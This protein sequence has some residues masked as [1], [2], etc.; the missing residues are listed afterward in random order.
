[1]SSSSRRNPPRSSSSRPNPP[2]S[3]RPASSLSPPRSM[4][5]RSRSPSPAPSSDPGS[6]TDRQDELEAALIAARTVPKLVLDPPTSPKTGSRRPRLPTSP[7]QMLDSEVASPSRPSAKR[8]RGG[9]AAKKGKGKEKAPIKPEPAKKLYPLSHLPKPAPSFWA[10]LAASSA[11]SASAFSGSPSISSPSVSPAPALPS[12]A[13]PSIPAIPSPLLSAF[14]GPTAFAPAP[15]PSPAAPSSSAPSAA[16]SSA[17]PAA[18]SSTPTVVS[19]APPLSADQVLSILQHPLFNALLANHPAA[20]PGLD[21]LPAPSVGLKAC[22]HGLPPADP[23]MQLDPNNLIDHGLV[24]HI[25]KEG[26]QT[27]F[28][29]NSLL[30]DL[31]RAVFLL[32]G[33]I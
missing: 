7:P 27:Y 31:T 22:V 8:P 23:A 10:S 1:M 11:S 19:S 30:A 21:L 15:S 12:P 18:P 28:P 20:V 32:E 26:W 29:I 13:F 16:P 5:F 24:V 25:L 6:P 4:D 9:S 14:S 2:C 33:L 17:P 3:S